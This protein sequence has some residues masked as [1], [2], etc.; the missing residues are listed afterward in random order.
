MGSECDNKEQYLTYKR[1][2]GL[3]EVD[4]TEVRVSIVKVFGKK[5][6]LPP[7]AHRDGVPSYFPRPN[8]IDPSMDVLM[9]MWM[10]DGC[11][12]WMKVCMM[13]GSLSSTTTTTM[14][15]SSRLPV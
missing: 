5:F 8:S 14:N 2:S 3:R 6:T 12:G 4:I 15:I 11:E 9:D 13:K 1:G 7:D 10:D